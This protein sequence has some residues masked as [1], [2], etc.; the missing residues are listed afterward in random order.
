MKKLM[1]RKCANLI[2]YPLE[3]NGF[4]KTMNTIKEKMKKQK[5][6]VSQN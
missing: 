5:D 3:Q 4:N 6:I 1:Q 2:P